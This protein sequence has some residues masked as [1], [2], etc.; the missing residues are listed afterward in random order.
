MIL[1][2]SLPLRLTVILLC[3]LPGIMSLAEDWPQWRGVQRDGVWRSEGITD[4][5]PDGQIPLQWSV[6]IGPG[7]SGPTVADGRVYVSDR[8][9]H[10]A[11]QT[12]RVLCFDSQSGKSIWTHT[13]D[14]TYSIGYTA[15]PRASVTVDQGRA[16]SVGAMGHFYC[17]DA[18]SGD[19]IWQRDLNE[20]YQIRMPVWGIAAAP[21][22]YR[23]FVIQQVSGQDGACMV[24]FNKATGEEAWKALDEP[25]GYSS[26]ILYK[27][28]GKDVLVCWTGESLSGLDPA[29]GKVYWAHEMKP[30]QMPIGIATPS[31]E[32]DLIFVSSFY[33]GS[34]M[35]RAPHDQLTSEVVWR[36]IGR[37]E[38]NT[39]ALHSMIGTPIVE[40]NYVYGFDSYGEM[41]CL[42]ALT[43]KR[44]WE[45][46]TA[47]PKARWSTVHMVRQ[48]DRVWMF[49]ERGELLIASLSPEGLTIH[50]RS[51][52]IE[53]TT[54]QLPQRG[55]VCWAHPAFAE[56]SIF[57]R[58]DKQLVRASLAK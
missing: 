32:G 45:D 39:L 47:V 22:V 52:L 43:G 2:S 31:V 1:M 3:S 54:T 28:A 27:Q 7:Y 35:I 48:D 8:Q 33:D 51:Q 15:G 42:E 14:A 16:Y 49:N 36:E 41:R 17:F 19:V 6:P 20:D 29:T 44:V 12:E 13:Y 5:L 4:D 11:K 30:R 50:D 38:K 18:H 25:A 40:D 21:I 34:L 56:K 46:L 9:A 23:D 57:V 55:G 10:G 26:P 58:N 53:P 24:A 37:D